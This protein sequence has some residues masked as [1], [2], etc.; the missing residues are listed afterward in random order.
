MATYEVKDKIDG[1]SFVVEATS[2][3]AAIQRAARDRYEVRT[4]TNAAEAARLVGKGA[5]FLDD[6]DAA[7]GDTPAD[8][9]EES[10]QAENDA[11]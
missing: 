9:N 8:E 3:S 4:V 2:N 5:E 7:P 10:K 1:K 6:E 11:G